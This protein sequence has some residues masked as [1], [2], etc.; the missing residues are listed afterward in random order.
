MALTVDLSAQS[1]IGLRDRPHLRPRPESGIYAARAECAEAEA[2]ELSKQLA[3]LS[4]LPKL[5]GI[6]DPE[7]PRVACFR[8]PA[9]S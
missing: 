3:R 7:D 4:D 6:H 1:H 9:R 5:S 2:E 8:T